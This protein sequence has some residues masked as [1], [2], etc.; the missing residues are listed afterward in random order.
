MTIGHGTNASPAPTHDARLCGSSGRG[1][2]LGALADGRL[3]LNG[4]TGLSGSPQPG[5]KMAV[6]SLLRRPLMA[7]TRRDVFVE[8]QSIGY[9]G[10]WFILLFSSA[11][12]FRLL[13]FVFEIVIPESDNQLHWM[14]FSSGT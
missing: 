1:A 2:W 7:V 13:F 8:I 5:E 14:I 9:E 11:T 12:A 10:F 3:W 6:T 4:D